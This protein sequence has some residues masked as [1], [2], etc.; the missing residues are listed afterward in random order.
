MI[1]GLVPV[2]GHAAVRALL[3]TSPLVETDSSLRH[4]VALPITEQTTGLRF[5][6]FTVSNRPGVGITGTQLP[7][8]TVT[9]I[10]FNES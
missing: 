10:P 7:R 4:F 2:N 1:A 8:K 6:S 9:E 5:D 3:P